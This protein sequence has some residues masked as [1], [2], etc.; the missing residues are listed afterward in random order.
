V[1]PGNWLLI[2]VAVSE[3]NGSQSSK[4]EEAGQHCSRGLRSNAMYGF[5]NWYTEG[6][7][8]H[9][10]CEEDLPEEV[11]HAHTAAL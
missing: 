7:E 8:A 6:A 5:D 10:R 9:S 4:T 3:A 11:L 1:R 2:M